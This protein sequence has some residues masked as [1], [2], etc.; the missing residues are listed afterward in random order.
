MTIPTAA[1]SYIMAGIWTGHPRK[2]IHWQAAS[3]RP[4]QFFGQGI[5]HK[6]F[7]DDLLNGKNNS[8]TARDAF[9]P[10][11][12]VGRPALLL[13]RAASSACWASEGGIEHEKLG[14]IVEMKDRRTQ[15]TGAAGGP[16]QQQGIDGVE[17]LF[18]PKCGGT[19][20]WTKSSLRL[21]EHP[22]SPLPAAW[23]LKHHQPGP[24][25]ARGDHAGISG[26]G[27]RPS[28]AG[29]RFSTPASTTRRTRARISLSSK[30]ISL[31]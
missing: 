30:K 31:L 15:P 12:V 27:G 28:A 25:R 20:R 22:W 14:F 29:W 2:D 7:V 8:K 21:K 18:N 3:C 4:G 1:I 6:T 19:S 23:W 13:N 16:A 5:Y 11:Q 26:Y 17:L 10:L 9:V 24:G